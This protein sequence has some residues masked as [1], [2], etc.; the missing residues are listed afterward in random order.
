[1]LVPYQVQ[2]ELDRLKAPR[3]NGRSNNDEKEAQAR[4]AWS[5]LLQASVNRSQVLMETA[6]QKPHYEHETTVDDQIIR[7][8]LLIADFYPKVCVVTGDNRVAG[9][10]EANGV[11][12]FGF[13]EDIKLFGATVEGY[14]TGIE[15]TAF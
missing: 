13:Y 11:K 15:P 10:C 4:K 2:M 8:A 14:L 1:M 3:R 9:V 12:C 6:H 7:R 5:Q